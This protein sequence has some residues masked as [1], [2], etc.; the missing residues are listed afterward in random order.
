MRAT[1]G[2]TKINCMRAKSSAFERGMIIGKFMDAPWGATQGSYRN[3]SRNKAH[4]RLDMERKEL[5]QVQ[6]LYT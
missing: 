2:A 6:K 1:S 4:A 5:I 3:E